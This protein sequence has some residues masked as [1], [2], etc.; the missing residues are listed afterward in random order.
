VTVLSQSNIKMVLVDTVSAT[1]VVAWLGSG[2]YSVGGH[3]VVVDFMRGAHSLY[4]GDDLY[5]KA[6]NIFGNGDAARALF[7][8][9]TF[10]KNVDRSSLKDISGSGSHQ[11]VSD[12]GDED[13]SDGDSGGGCGTKSSGGKSGKPGPD[14]AIGGIGA[15][16]G[17]RV[18]TLVKH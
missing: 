6:K 11:D 10:L 7:R 5:S 17:E 18:K 1:V 2:D 3:D 14:D 16:T 13:D 15:R 12:N 4:A 9:D 8:T